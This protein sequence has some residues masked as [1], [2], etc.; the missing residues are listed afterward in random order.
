MDGYGRRVRLDSGSAR[1]FINEQSQF[2]LCFLHLLEEPMPCLAGHRGAIACVC[3][4]IPDEGID[5][6]LRYKGS[7]EVGGDRAPTA[8]E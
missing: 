6:F 2:V 4:G 1:T 3:A 8:Q 5:R 7:I